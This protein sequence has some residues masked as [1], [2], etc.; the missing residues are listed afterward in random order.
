MTGFGDFDDVDA[1]AIGSPW[2]AAGYTADLDRLTGLIS[3]CVGDNTW[4]A[5]ETGDLGLALDLW[6][7]DELRRAGYEPDAVWP[8][9]INPRVLPASVARSIRRLPAS[10]RD[11]PIV[12][13]IEA[14]AGSV[15]AAVHGEFF[16]KAV[17][18]LVADWDRGVEL[19]VSTK[20]MV[21][22]FGKNLTN[23]WEEFVG[24]L[25]NIRGRFPMASLGVVFLADHSIVTAEP[26][27]Y[28]RLLD[29]L[30]KLRLVGVSG[31]SYDATMLLLAR[32]V[33]AGSA[34][35]ELGD[36]PPD[37]GPSQFY[38]ALLTRVF[39]RLPVSERAAARELYGRKE[40]P[41]AEAEPVSG[42]EGLPAT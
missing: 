10:R 41:T 21:S 37:L 31:G 36:M 9:A 8:R 23:R 34:I 11:D 39:V 29:M 30:R 35:L 13:R 3:R 14:S 1:P 15:G 6:V 26:N 24:D 16:P 25:R 4:R 18:V 42:P 12:K 5:R 19:M 32:P 33:G 28:Q 2:G 20:A 40:L 27:S 22:S 7:A 38:E 17:D